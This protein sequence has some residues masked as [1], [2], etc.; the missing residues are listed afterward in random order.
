MLGLAARYGTRGLRVVSTTVLLNP[1]AVTSEIATV[2]QVI[3]EEHMTYP[4][5]L[6]EGAAWAGATQLNRVPAFMVVGRDGR[7]VARV[8]GTLHQGG[9]E[10]GELTRAIDR[11]LAAAAPPRE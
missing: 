4:C 1:H 5:V 2:R 10:L 7:V 8:Y 6:D 9:S 11:A 3:A